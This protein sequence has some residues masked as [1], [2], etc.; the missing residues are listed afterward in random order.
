MLNEAVI[1]QII[2]ILFMLYYLDLQS[3]KIKIGWYIVKE[4]A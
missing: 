2:V 1:L 3:F 4:P